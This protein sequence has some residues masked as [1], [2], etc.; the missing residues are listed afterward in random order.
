MQKRESVVTWLLIV[1][2]L[3]VYALVALQGN[4]ED[5]LVLLK[6]GAKWAPAIFS[7]QWWR[8]LTAPF[9]HFG[10]FHLGMNLYA[11]Y[12]IGQQVE[13]LAGS[14]R[15]FLIYLSAALWGV[16][17]SLYF[18]PQSISAGA[19]GAIFGL[20]GSLLCFA[21]LY[22]HAV[23]PGALQHLVLVIGLNIFL[24]L[25]IPGIDN[26]AHIGGLVAG[27]FAA[28][29]SPF[30]PRSKRVLVVSCFGLNTLLSKVNAAIPQAGSWKELL[31]SGSEALEEKNYQEAVACLEE[32]KGKAPAAMDDLLSL[33]LA[34]AHFHLG[35]ELLDEDPVKAAQH[36]TSSIAN[37][38]DPATYHNLVLAY[39]TAGNEKKARE[40]LEVALEKYPGEKYLLDLE[41][42]IERRN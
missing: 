10:I 35:N 29:F 23:R 25:L 17:G 13:Y 15:F 37:R 22:R 38:A 5:P 4:P 18:S 11:L 34:E 7:G 26:F 20:V 41:R 19:S 16:L 27:F 28:Y 39:L 36:Y 3:M 1:L 12:S 9:L 31:A 42:E 2:N 8:F 32:A 21:L 14:L 6:Y 24:G 33:K 40:T 30:K